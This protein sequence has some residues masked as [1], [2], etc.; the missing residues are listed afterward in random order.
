MATRETHA[1]EELVS[2]ADI[3]VRTASQLRLH[4]KGIAVRDVEAI[5]AARQLL[6]NAQKGVAFVST[7][8]SDGLQSSLKPLNWAADVVWASH[9]TEKKDSNYEELQEFL[10]RLDRTLETLTST[11]DSAVPGAG[12]CLEFFASLGEILGT[13]AD[14]LIRQRT[15]P[16]A[17]LNV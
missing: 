17:E 15:T 7:G 1:L 4:Q 16:L 5:D 6:S 10:G 8:H 3:A 2:S 11:G 9:S 13:R 12:D 14:Q